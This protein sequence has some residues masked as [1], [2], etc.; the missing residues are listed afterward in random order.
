MKKAFRII[1]LILA[2]VM[3]A[4]VFAGCGNAEPEAADVD[5][6]LLGKWVSAGG[7][8]TMVFNADGTGT[9]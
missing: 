6:N 8:S 1:A 2:G 9:D 7:E 3:C 4:A 5:E